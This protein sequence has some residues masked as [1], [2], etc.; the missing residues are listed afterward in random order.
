M[1][2]KKKKEYEIACATTSTKDQPCP[3]KGGAASQWTEGA[4]GQQGERRAGRSDR[5]GTCLNL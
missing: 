5:W 3:A 1:S 2:Q 4:V